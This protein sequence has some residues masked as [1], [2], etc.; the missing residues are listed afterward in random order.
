MK[1][2]DLSVGGTQPG[3]Q[4]ASIGLLTSIIMFNM[5]IIEMLGT[6]APLTLET[7]ENCGTL[8]LGPMVNLGSLGFTLVAVGFT[9]VH[10]WFTG[11][12]SGSFRNKFIKLL[13]TFVL[14]IVI[15]HN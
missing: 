7:E 4:T 6:F 14:K 2:C 11:V 3:R 5:L 8:H 12:P 9:L 10:F 13:I 15:F 1:R